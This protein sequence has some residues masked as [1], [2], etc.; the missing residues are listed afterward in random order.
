MIET[1]NKITSPKTG[2]QFLAS[3]HFQI[4]ND[5]RWGPSHDPE[6][7]KSI[8]KK[9]YP[10]LPLTKRDRIASPKPA[11]IMHYD[12]RYGDNTSLTKSHF[13]EKP[14]TKRAQGDSYALRKT[15]FKA[16]SDEKLKSFQTTHKEYFPVRPLH[17]AKVM[18]STS[19]TEWMRSYIPQGDKEKELLPQSDYK[20]RFLGE[21]GTSGPVFAKGDQSGRLTITGDPR[22]QNGQFVTTAKTEF[23]KR[24]LPKQKLDPSLFAGGS[25]I[26]QGDQEKC[27][28]TTSTQQASF[29]QR[30]ISRE[31]EPFNKREAVKKLRQTTFQLGDQRSPGFLQSTASHSYACP[32][33]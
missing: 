21:Q 9:D 17:E 26:P 5:S 32:S 10:P 19:K 14:L 12:H 15:N 13:V 30:R 31:F 1:T 24:Y 16:D 3:S 22:T 2:T 7:Y 28:F 11:G 18:P 29:P 8:F 6:A 33:M 27:T 4:S 23:I 20:S 25:N